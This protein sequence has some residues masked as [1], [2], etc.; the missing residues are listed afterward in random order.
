MNP[1]HPIII[2]DSRE[3]T[4]LTF[5][6]FPF[7]CGTLQSGDYS[8]AG[9]EG[10]FTVERKSIADLIGS[11]AAG[12][13]EGKIKRQGHNV[14]GAVSCDGKPINTV[15]VSDRMRQRMTIS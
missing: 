4:P 8:V 11:L 1:E 5:E 2:I 9:H 7:R 3:Q 15:P 12:R 13:E 10:R 6:H 14:S